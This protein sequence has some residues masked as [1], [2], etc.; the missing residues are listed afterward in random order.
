MV[1]IGAVIHAL[2]AAKGALRRMARR[3]ARDRAQA[4]PYS[5]PPGAPAGRAPWSGLRDDDDALTDPA[6]YAL[7]RKARRRRF[8]RRPA[9]RRSGGGAQACE[10]ARGRGQV[11][12][13]EE[14]VDH[15]L[16]RDADRAEEIG[17][18]Q[19]FAGRARAERPPARRRPRRFRRQGRDRQ[20]APGPGRR[21]LRARTRAG[22]QIVAGDRACR[23]HRAID[24][25]GLGPR[26]RGAGPQ[27]HRHRIAEPAPRDGLPARIARERGLREIEASPRH[28]AR[29][30][31]RRRAGDRRP[32]PHAA[33]AGRRHDRLGQVGGDQHHDPLA[34]LPHEARAV[35]AHHGRSE[36]ARA[37]GLRRH[38]A[39]C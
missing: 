5:R 25:G 4:L 7:R 2:L 24:V 18:D 9:R 6:A 17:R 13:A 10:P 3:G 15:A 34:A 31:D 36:D 37:L 35:P 1:S 30:D 16:D 29:Q 19:D 21:A 12:P 38:P 33:S 32:R 22:H 28:R 8:G 39:S 20:R 14:R 26:R 27:R 23:R 11:R